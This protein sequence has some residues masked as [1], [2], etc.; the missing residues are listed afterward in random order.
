VKAGV[1]TI[2]L[3]TVCKAFIEQCG[4]PA[5][6]ARMMLEDM[7]ACKPGSN[8]RI[9]LESAILTALSRI[10]EIDDLSS[11]SDEEL[12]M[13]A[14]EAG[15]VESDGDRQD[16]TG[17]PERGVEAPQGRPEAV[18]PVS[19]GGGISQAEGEVAFGGGTEPLR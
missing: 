11:L 18:P 17:D 16:E 3:G 4:G 15:I 7:Q 1:G 12:Q 6:F 10:D 13:L 19:L 8:P 14:K 5:A 9:R 2:S